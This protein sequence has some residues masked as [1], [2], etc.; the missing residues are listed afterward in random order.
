[1]ATI[2][3]A[4]GDEPVMPGAAPKAPS[5]LSFP[6]YRYFWLAR[7]TAVMATMA[8]VVVIGYQLYDTARTDYGMSIREASFQL[9]LLGLV[10]FVPLAILTPVAGWV[11]DRLERRSV[12][13]FSNLID[14]VIAALLG[15]FTWT[16]ALTLP[17]L[18]GLAALHG[19]ARVFS[20]PAMSAIAPNIVP[21][22]VLPRAIAMS[23]IAWQ[24]AS[25]VGPAAGGLIYAAH[26]ASVY[27][28]A[29]IL[30]AISAFTISRVRPVLP[31]PSEVRRHP[32]REMADG[33]QF[34]W[35][36]RFLLGTI[37]LDLFAVILSGA[38]ALLPVFARD[39]LQTGSEGLGFLRAAPAVGAAVVALGLA[40]R[41][42][43]RNVGVKMLWAVAV[44]GA[45]TVAFGL[46]TNFFLS[47]ALL[48][49]MGAADMF[50]VFVRGTLIQLNTPDHM[51]GRVSAVSGLAISASNEL[52][53]MRAGSMAAVF[54]PIPAVVFG[55][56]AAI[57]VTALWAWLFPELRR[58]RTFEPQF[59]QP[60]D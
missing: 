41:P 23:S 3:P 39:I 35:R 34:T 58:A 14:L 45:G 12:A 25:V 47:L 4:D 51:R 32:L 49:L 8:M 56:V 21:P 43:E 27:V 5:P 2:P 30:L 19:V 33:L 36:E 22:A 15:W 40:F 10:Q 46:S 26:P 20:G 24:S 52:G 11:A 50:S 9:G 48:V 13:I 54:G 7:F 60:T 37:T 17:L 31:P 44:F 59:K 53:E 55:G 1:M 38:T 57:G 42:I 16:D 28:F 29:A 18:F 6:D